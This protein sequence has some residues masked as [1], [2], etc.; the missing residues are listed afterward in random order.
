LKHL[1]RIC[2]RNCLGHQ[3][4]QTGHAPFLCRSE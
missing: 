2:R 1:A 3:V 4:I